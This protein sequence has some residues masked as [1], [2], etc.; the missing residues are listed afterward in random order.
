MSAAIEMP[1]VSAPTNLATQMIYRKMM[2]RILPFLF[3]CYIVNQLDRLNI[4]FAK[5]RFMADIG[6]TDMAYGVG[7]GVFFIGYVVFEVPSN[8]YLQRVGARATF[9]RIMVLWGGISVA[10]CL[11]TS[12]IQFYIARFLLGAAEAGFVPGVILYLTYWFPV[13]YRARITAFFFMA[14][15]FSGI[16][17]GPLS[18]WILK[19]FTN[20]GH[21]KD[22][23]WLF[24]LEGMPAI[25]LGVFA[26]FYLADKPEDAKWL[27]KSEK[28]I[29]RDDLLTDVKTKEVAAESSLRTAF[30]N[31]KVY[32]AGFV[33]FAIIAGNNAM[34]LWMPTLIKELGVDDIFMIGLISGIPYV[35]GAF[36]MYF[37]SRHSDKSLERR[38]HVALP[39]LLTAASYALVGSLMHH[40]LVAIT[41]LGLAAAG[42]YSAIAIFWTIPPAYLT[43]KAAAAGIG[44]VSSIG[45]MGGFASPIIVGWAK[46]MTGSIQPGFWAISVILVLGAVT[47]L[48]GIP[49]ALLEHR[50][51]S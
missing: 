49:A 14:I 34:T 22:W 4:S 26:Y 37:A 31:P 40:P 12:P 45:M 6:L 30:M 23:Q 8:L 35:V 10:M 47:L 21:L 43:G 16:I 27:S 33:Y 5:L 24:I 50:K 48:A 36:C 42:I 18:G 9:I 19:N 44:L 7:A 2:L 39:I 3:I 1:A 29:V 20:V 17:G 41:L 11:V 28:K 13:R 25:V 38:W 51:K 46:T 15:T 32:I